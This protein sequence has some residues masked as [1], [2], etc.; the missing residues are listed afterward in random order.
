MATLQLRN[1]TS[2]RVLFQY[3]GKR[4]NL[5]VGQVSR[6]D[7]E[8]VMTQVDLILGRIKAGLLKVPGDVDIVEVVRYG[9]VIPAKA[10]PKL[11]AKVKL[12]LARLHSEYVAA[13]KNSL[14]ANTLGE[15][16]THFKHLKETFGES[17]VV[18]ILELGDLQRHV[19]RRELMKNSRGKTISAV[20]V[21]KDL[22]SFRIAWRWAVEGKLLTGNFPRMKSV[23]FKPTEDKLPFMTYAEVERQLAQGGDAEK[24]WE[25]LYLDPSELNELLEHIRSRIEAPEWLYPMVCLAAFTGVRRSELTRAE[26]ADLDLGLLV[27]TVREKKRKKGTST[28][29]RV[30]IAKPLEPILQD[31]LAKRPSGVPFLFAEFGTRL[32]S[33][34]RGKTTGNKT[35]EHGRG[36]NV[37]VRDAPTT[38][39]VT[40]DAASHHLDRVLAAS[41]KWKHLKGWHILRHSFISACANKGVDQ[42]VI[43]E[44]VGHQSEEQ[45][46]RY[47]HLYPKVMKEAINRVFG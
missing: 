19:K 13:H 25:C 17:F 35:G 41:E 24:L 40:P 31:W 11:Q 10:A 16:E 28:T 18:E 29:R 34:T 12:T 20:T 22:V 14:A 3:D 27:I 30:P 23:R 4:F 39:G 1:G 36:S 9:G 43:D 26:V 6:N 47:R 37:I 8:L 7:A 38:S 46:K 42:R 21:Q 2:Y 5:P 32:R 15:I 33:R 44:V 45:R